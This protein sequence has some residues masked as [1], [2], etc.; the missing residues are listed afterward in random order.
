MAQLCATLP[1]STSAT[2]LA[3]SSSRNCS[4]YFHPL[5]LPQALPNWNWREGMTVEQVAAEA[6]HTMWTPPFRGLAHALYSPPGPFRQQPTA[7][8]ERYH[9]QL[10][11]EQEQEEAPQGELRHPHHPLHGYNSLDKVGP[12]PELGLRAALRYKVNGQAWAQRAHERWR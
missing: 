12:G 8:L 4:D 9:I 5:A 11:H 2:L 7:G 1:T 6:I 10:A 3:A